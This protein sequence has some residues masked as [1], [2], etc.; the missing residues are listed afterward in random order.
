MLSRKA[1]SA[2]K[3]CDSRELDISVSGRAVDVF[4]IDARAKVS[5]SSRAVGPCF[6]LALV[7]CCIIGDSASE[8]C[9][10]VT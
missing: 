6:A 5:A 8:T 4:M 9:G 10:Q 2:A 1:R 3:I 7:A